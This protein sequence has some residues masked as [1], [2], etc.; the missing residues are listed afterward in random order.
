MCV[1]VCVCV[2][3][4]ERERESVDKGSKIATISVG[5]LAKVVLALYYVFHAVRDGMDRKLTVF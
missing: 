1:C 2:C 5:L 4:R 3:V